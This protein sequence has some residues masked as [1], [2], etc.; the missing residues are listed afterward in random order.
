MRKVASLDVEV[1][2]LLTPI[3]CLAAPKM[4]VMAMVPMA[5]RI[6][7]VLMKWRVP[8]VCKDLSSGMELGGKEEGERGEGRWEGRG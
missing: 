6:V 8:M 1:T 7:G 4:V 3:A 5:W 2:S